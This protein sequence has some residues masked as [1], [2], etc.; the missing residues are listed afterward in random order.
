[1]WVSMVLFEAVMGRERA[2]VMGG[3]VGKVEGTEER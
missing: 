2:S 3:A 1:M